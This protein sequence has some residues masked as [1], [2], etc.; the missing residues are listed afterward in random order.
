MARVKCPKCGRERVVVEGKKKN[1]RRCGTA[2]ST[3]GPKPEKPEKPPTAEHLAERYPAQIEEIKSRAAAEARK[4]V[5]QDE[6][7]ITAEYIKADCPELI[8]QLRA[9]IIE[10]QGTEVHKVSAEEIKQAQIEAEESARE[11]AFAAVAN[12]SV[13]KFGEQFPHLAQKIQKAVI[14]AY[15]KKA[16]TD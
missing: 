13:P 16:T 3:L 1:C 11:K 9:E 14:A 10:E 12:L 2:L 6:Y 5:L 7:E 4:Q 8:E 15:K